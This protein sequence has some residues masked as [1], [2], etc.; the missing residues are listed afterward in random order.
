MTT[1]PLATET[2][3]ACPVCG[4]AQLRTVETMP[5][6]YIPLLVLQQCAQCGVVLLNPRLTHASVVAVENESTVYNMADEEAEKIVAGPLTGLAQH[7][8]SFSRSGGRRWL[9]IGCNRG[10]LLEAARRLGWEVV[11]V[12]IADEAAQRA[13]Q[14][15]GLTVHA[16]LDALTEQAPFDVIT[17][18]HVL[19][20]TT[21][22][23]GFLRTATA[24]LA[25][26]GVLALQV[27]AYDYRAEFAERGQI[28]SL[29]CTVHNFYFTATGLREVLARTQLHPLTIDADAEHLLLT[30]ICTN[31]APTVGWRQRLRQWLRL[32]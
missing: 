3:A 32:G 18:W 21:D 15:W 12:E 31:D 17:A 20:H 1:L 24:M 22:P 8:S 6:A 19:E 11:G 25:P 14:Q 29:I 23:V 27:P 4:G 2:L 13:R 5:D 9:D 7:L 10:L 26:G 16:S 30:A 28:G